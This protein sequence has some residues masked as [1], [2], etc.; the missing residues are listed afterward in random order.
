MR[1][2]PLRFSLEPPIVR[3][4][5]I[6]RKRADLLV[7]VE[8]KEII[9]ALAGDRPNSSGGPSSK[10]SI[11]S[12]AACEICGFLKP[13]GL[14][15]PFI[16]GNGDNCSLSSSDPLMIS[17]KSIDSLFRWTR[18]V[19]GGPPFIPVSLGSAEAERWTLGDVAIEVG[20]GGGISAFFL[21][22][23][24]EMADTETERTRRLA[25]AAAAAVELACTR[26]LWRTRGA[27]DWYELGGCADAGGGG[28]A[29]AGG[30]W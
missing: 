8:E 12:L 15:T 14:P 3:R 27:M 19:R 23:F 10:N 18:R 24:S 13:V 4:D 16:C 25:A 5:I 28:G 26:L 11:S 30:G 21:G 7:F 9:L 17:S 20:R 2:I 1:L 29:D 6:L 22:A